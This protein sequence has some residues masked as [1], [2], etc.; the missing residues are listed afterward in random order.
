MKEYRLQRVGQTIKNVK[1][2][3]QTESQDQGD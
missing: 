3:E 1:E 2:S